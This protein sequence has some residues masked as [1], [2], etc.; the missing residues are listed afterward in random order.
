MSSVILVNCM[1]VY[2]LLCLCFCFCCLMANLWFGGAFVGGLLVVC[3]AVLLLG[4]L[5]FVCLGLRI[6]LICGLC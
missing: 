5:R 3:F 1:F 2:C 4:W 6:V